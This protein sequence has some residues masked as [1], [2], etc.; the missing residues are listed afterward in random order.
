MRCICTGEKN[1]SHMCLL[2]AHLAYLFKH[3]ADD[4]LDFKVVSTILSSQVYLMSNYVFDADD[5]LSRRRKDKKK[6]KNSRQ[7]AEDVNLSI[8]ITQ[9]EI[10]ELF[11]SKRWQIYRWLE[12]NPDGCN[13]VMESI[14]R[15]V[16]YTGTRAAAEEGAL[17]A[18]VWRGMLSQHNKGRFV[19]DT[20]A[21]TDAELF[22]VT[23]GQ[24]YEA[25]LRRCTTQAIETEINIQTGEFTLKKR[26]T[27]QV[28]LLDPL[29]LLS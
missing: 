6:S 9:T 23:P 25:W 29:A 15:V 14:V 11:Q 18:R 16:T 3:N 7:D 1:V 5:H 26:Q 27:M 12:A 10:F 22:A 20:E 4:A 13:E 2:R 24:S 28:R 17:Q 19:P 8:G 21:K